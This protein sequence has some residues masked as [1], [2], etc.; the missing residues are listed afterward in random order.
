MLALGIHTLLAY[1]SMFYYGPITQ[2]YKIT[3]KSTE[4][5]GPKFCLLGHLR[6]LGLATTKHFLSILAFKL[7]LLGASYAKFQAI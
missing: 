3:D 7:P 1:L 2:K 6:T 5:E 4:I